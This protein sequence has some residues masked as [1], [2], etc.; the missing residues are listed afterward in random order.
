MTLR[1]RFLA[2]YLENEDGAGG[3]SGGAN[4][5]AGGNGNEDPNAGGRGSAGDGGDGGQR[6]GSVTM[7]QDELDKL[8]QR[9]KGKAERAAQKRFEDERRKA[10]MTEAEKLKAEKET[11]QKERDEARSAAN[12]R[13]IRADAKDAL[14]DKGVP[15]E[16][17]E[18]ALKLID[19]GGVEVDEKGEPDATAISRAVDLLLKDIPELTGGS[20]GGDKGGS[21]MG[22]GGGGD[23]LTQEQIDKMTPEEYGK[24]LSR[25]TA[26]YQRKQAKT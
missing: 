26:F 17:I 25:I 24:N 8:I 23:D 5:D 9:E 12:S 1:D 19:L 15:R 10:D 3:G 11:A 20:S 22:G 18:R 14:R 16:K 7:S 2:W 6:P 21:D 4:G 13:V